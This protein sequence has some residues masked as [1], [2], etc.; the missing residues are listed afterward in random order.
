MFGEILR[1]GLERQHV[2]LDEAA[3]ALPQFLDFG[4]KSEIHA[5][6]PI[7]FYQE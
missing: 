4:R 6:S 3:R 5:A 7:D 1:V 2:L